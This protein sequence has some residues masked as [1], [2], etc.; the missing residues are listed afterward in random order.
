MPQ[1]ITVRAMMH[2]KKIAPREDSEPEA[3]LLLSNGLTAADGGNVR[4]PTVSYRYIRRPT[5]S[6]F[7]PRQYAEAQT[8][9][10]GEPPLGEPPLGEEDE[11]EPGWPNVSRPA[12][13]SVAIH[14]LPPCAWAK[15][16]VRGMGSSTEN[17][18][19]CRYRQ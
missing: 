4:R 11:P 17:Q 2:T 6:R 15:P 18:N 1:S 7:D 9:P 12:T 19:E 8:P 10:L 3:Q 16:R 14:I 5:R 13:A